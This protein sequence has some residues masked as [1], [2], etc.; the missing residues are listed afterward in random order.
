MVPNVFGSFSQTPTTA[1][2]LASRAA[3]Q[4]A[5]VSGAGISTEF[6]NSSV[7]S[8]LERAPVAE[9]WWYQTGCAGMKPSGKPI[10]RAPLRPAS[11]ISRQAFSVEPSRSR[12]TDAACTAAT[13]TIEATSPIHCPSAAPNS[14]QANPARLLGRLCLR[15]GVGLRPIVGRLLRALERFLGLEAGRHRRV[16]AGENLVV[17]DVERAQPALLAHGQ[18]DEKADLDQFGLAEMLVQPLPELVV[19][20][21]VPGDRLRI[22]ERRL[23]SLIVTARTFEIDQ[24]AIVVLD[25]AGLGGLHRALVAAELAQHRA[26]DIDAA[27][28]LDR[29]VG[30][31]VLEHVAPA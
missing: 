11:R 29:M 7:A 1:K 12:K 10:S 25:D 31:A 19:R 20:R 22:G 15:L 9:W 23:L 14:D 28:L 17:L 8:R 16:G 2:A 4:S 21:Q 18:R 5:S 13:F 6:L 27:E 24:I 30:D 26:R 3:A